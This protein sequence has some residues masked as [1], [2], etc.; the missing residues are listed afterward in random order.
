MSTAAFTFDLNSGDMMLAAFGGTTVVMVA[1]LGLF[2][3]HLDHRP[4]REYGYRLSRSWWYDL[5][6]GIGLG[7][8]VVAL[9]FVIGRYTNSL[10]VTGT[11]LLP[12]TASVGRF[13]LFFAAFAGVAFYEEYIYRGSFVTNAVEGLSARGISGPVATTLAVLTSTLAFAAIHVPG[14]IAGE[15]NISLVL[16][17]TGL[18]GG[19]LGIAYI[20]TDELAF[21]MGVHLGVNYALM[22]VFGIG[23]AKV[24]GVPTVLT[25]EHTTTG[26]W[27][28]ARGIPIF[29]AV[30]VG[31]VLVFAW[32]RWRD[33]EPTARTR[34]NH[35][36]GN[37][38]S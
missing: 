14:A 21:P 38:D 5:V 19:L 37:S 1:L 3:R 9:T 35:V 30:L 34:N 22:N 8:I 15:A 6:V 4:V 29:L 18:L 28:P 16:V 26:L 10:R 25:V 11:G 17:K 13:L 7:M 2:A 20:W 27:S 24:S 32:A 12:E 23:A 33:A 31:Y 36:H